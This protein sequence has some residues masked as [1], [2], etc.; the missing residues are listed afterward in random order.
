MQTVDHPMLTVSIERNIS[1]SYTLRMS[2]EIGSLSF[3][4]TATQGFECP[5]YC[6]TVCPLASSHNLAE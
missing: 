6:L 1:G 2:R 4:A 5:V 3:K